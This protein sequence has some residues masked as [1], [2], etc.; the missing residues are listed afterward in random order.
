MAN[1]LA[2]NQYAQLEELK[3]M[4]NK[5]EMSNKE[6]SD[7]LE[8]LILVELRKPDQDINNKWIDECITLMKEVDNVEIANMSKR[9]ENARQSILSI[10]PPHKRR[11]LIWIKAV[12]CIAACIV[13]IFGIGLI[14][15]F[16]W[17]KGIQTQD[18]QVYFVEG[19]EITLGNEANADDVSTRIGECETG[20]FDEFCTFLGFAPPQPT[21]LPE[22]WEIWDY[23]A[24]VDECDQ[25]YAVTY[26]KEGEQYHLTYIHE[27]ADDVETLAISIPQDGTGNYVTLDNGLN[28]YLTM[29]VDRPVA[30]WTTTNGC[31]NISGP[32]TTEELIKIISSI[33]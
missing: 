27:T 17:I 2:F 20:D 28:I 13:L 16:T 29:N 4:Y 10:T 9:A 19:H 12:S 23:Y 24:F 11:E 3:E 18:T 26:A 15:H 1:S 8:L 31:S 30:V 22:G 32:V 5:A 6:I 25:F 33:Q 7:I 14:G 21:W